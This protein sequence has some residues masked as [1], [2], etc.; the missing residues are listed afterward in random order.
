MSVLSAVTAF[1]LIFA[2]SSKAGTISTLDQKATFIRLCT[3]VVDEYGAYLAGAKRP[4]NII[5]L[6]REYTRCAEVIG[7]YEDL[8]R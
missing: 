7:E 1:T 8:R 3:R 4:K 6:Q 2:A 5:A